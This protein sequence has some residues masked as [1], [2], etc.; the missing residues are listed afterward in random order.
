MNK[1][2]TRRI[3]IFLALAFGI[4]WSCAVIIYMTGGLAGSPVLIPGTG[5]TLA[6][7][8]L[9]TVYMASPALA[10]IMTRLLTGEGWHETYLRPRFRQGWPYWVAGW[11]GPA[12]LTLAGAALF[13]LIF[14]HY[15]D[16]GLGTLTDLLAQSGVPEE[17]S[18]WLIVIGQTAA[19]I[20]ISPLVNGLFTFGEEFGWRA[21]LQ[22]KLLP[23]GTRKTFLWMGLIWG[24]WHWPIIAMGHNYGLDYRGAPWLGML[25]MVWFTFVTG[26]FLGWIA[27]RGGSVWPAV[28]GHAAL[29]GIASLALLFVVGQPN[30]L[31]GP[32]PV[33]LIGSLPWALVTGWIFLNVKK[34]TASE[35]GSEIVR[36]IE[37]AP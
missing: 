28:I 7:V 12:L 22:P 4:A 14:P 24:I 36:P 8:L 16:A 30:L 37:I 25:A 34:S 27:L 20:L 13:F 3:V 5:I 11:F 10:H 29:N 35:S 15:F 19:A 9:A 17:I 32:L 1:L 23:I 18:P 26:T 31:L 33:G 21:Y 6:I 2:D